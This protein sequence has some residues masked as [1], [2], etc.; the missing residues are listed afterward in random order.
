MYKQLL[1]VLYNV[2]VCIH[3]SSA[4]NESDFSNSRSYEM[5]IVSAKQQQK[6]EMLYSVVNLANKTKKK[7][8][9][10]DKD[11][12]LSPTGGNGGITPTLDNPVYMTG[13]AAAA[14]GLDHQ[15]SSLNHQVLPAPTHDDQCSEEQHSS[16]QRDAS[17]AAAA[18]SDEQYSKLK[19]DIYNQPFEDDD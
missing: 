7:G 5:P 4:I 3:R 6:P 8:N 1:L 19:I 18:D 10:E 17:T 13:C 11:G 12:V 16:T 9:K 2:I 14:G 15:Y